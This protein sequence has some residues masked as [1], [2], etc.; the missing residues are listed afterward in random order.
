MQRFI[1]SL[2]LRS[3]LLVLVT[4]LSGLSQDLKQRD[5]LF[6]RLKQSR[7]D[8]N[9]VNIWLSLGRYY[10][11]KPGD[12]QADT[13][14]A[15]NYVKQAEKLSNTL[16]HKVGKPT[17]NHINVL[18]K[19][20]EFYIFKPLELA[21]DTDSAIYYA[22]QAGQLSQLL[23][24]PL[25]IKALQLVGNAFFEKHDS[26]RAQNYFS[27]A[28]RQY[29]QRNDTLQLALAWEQFGERT[30]HSRKNLLQ[31][32]DCYKKALWYYH[33][34]KN[35]ESEMRM[36]G[37][38]YYTFSLQQRLDLALAELK[39]ILRVYKT[40]KC[41][42]TDII[43]FEMAEA[44]IAQ[45]NFQTAVG[46]DLQA[47]QLIP[48]ADL[49]SRAGRVYYQLGKIYFYMNDDDKRLGYY[50]KSLYYYKKAKDQDMV[51]M[52]AGRVC[53]LLIKK[54]KGTEAFSFYKHILK[55][56]PPS[57]VVLKILSYQNLASV[58]EAI[59]DYD[60]AESYYRELFALLDKYDDQDPLKRTTYNAA[61]K[62]YLSQKQ[63]TKA[64]YYFTRLF[65]ISER[66]RNAVDRQASHYNFFLLDS[67]QGNLQSALAHLQQYIALKDSTLSATKAKQIEEL[68]IRY[69][70]Q[71]KVHRIDLLT[72]Q[73]RE[74]Q[75]R[76]QQAN[77]TRNVTFGGATMLLLL[78]GL[79]Y[80]RYRLKQ[81]QQAEIQVKNQALEELVGQKEWL[82]KELHHRVKNNLQLIISLLQSQGK[83]LLDK[84]AISAIEQ[85]EHRVRAMALIHQKLY[86]DENISQID[87]RAYIQEVAEQ[88]SH[89]FDPEQRITFHY[90]LAPLELDVSQAIPLGLIINEAITNAFK[91]AFPHK[92]AGSIWLFL[93]PL[94]TDQYRLQVK[95]DGVGL[96]TGVDFQQSN[97]M[98]A[99]I[100]RGL[101]QQL[102]SSLKVTSGQGL[103]VSV[104]F[105]IFNPQAIPTHAV[106]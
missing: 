74:Q 37:Y 50:K 25:G 60:Q 52:V 17:S 84:S 8:T 48:H 40:E 98:G 94:A 15:T 23:H 89:S 51:H 85:S 31:K 49:D 18:L 97:S 53:Q 47:L 10:L 68:Q 55:E 90:D 27:Q 16:V 75:A 41:A 64:R 91:Y 73:A 35:Q 20:S 46:Y 67:T 76:V 83:Y 1:H 106:Y 44:E 7:T 5:E 6:A 78:L 88:L 36:V 103:D 34:L 3:I 82:L 33:Q 66:T 54:R 104:L 24:G 92:Q 43:Y 80:N 79:V 96:P 12:L 28:I 100:M 13:D 11:D 101:S 93:C 57:S 86:R 22:N 19:L 72:S 99:Y 30:V 42:L 105:E 45:G 9:R 69:D 87:M 62:F 70:T 95:D 56:Y 77:L 102:G 39:T 29:E 59:Q 81:T 38:M 14:S 2:L 26:L 21:S 71:N 63:Y 58:Y 65:S 4:A 61:G 32:T